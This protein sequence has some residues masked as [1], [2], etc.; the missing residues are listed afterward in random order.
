[1]KFLTE[2]LMP[3]TIFLQNYLKPSVVPE[4]Q[5]YFQMLSRKKNKVI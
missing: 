4:L 2:T 5:T 3:T 1:M